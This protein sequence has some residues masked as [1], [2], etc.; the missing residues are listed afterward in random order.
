M[1]LLLTG[2]LAAAQDVGQLG[3]QKPFEIN[4]VLGLGLGTYH[5]DGIQPR[6]HDFSYLFNGAPI[7]SIY[8]I[9]LPFNIVVSDQ[10]RGFRQPFNQYGISP[11]YKWVT[12]HLGWQSVQF[13]QFT[14][15]GYD[16]L[17]GGVELNPGKWRLGFIYGRFNKAI[18]ETSSQP[19]SFQTPTYKRTGY[20]AKIGYG[21]E[22]THVDL[23]LLNAK[24]DPHSIHID[25]AAITPAENLVVGLDAKVSF[26]KHFVWDLDV[27]GSIYTRNK[28][29]DTIPNLELQ[30]FGFIKQMVTLNASSQLL[31]A[32]QT[33]LA[34]QGTNYTVGLQYRRVDPDYKSMGAYYFE[35]DV[36]NYTANGNLRLINNQVQLTGSFGR[37]HDNLLHDKSYTSYRNIGAL[38]VSYN[39]P[40]YGIDVHYSDFGITQDRGLNPIIDTFRV[41]RTNY[42]VNALLRY[43]LTDS[44]I[45]HSFIL[46]GTIQ[47]LADL[48]HFTAGQDETN[49]KTVNLSYQLGFIKSAF[50]VNA[51]YSYT[52]ADIPTMHT[53]LSGPSFTLSKQVDKGKIGLNATTSFQF[54]HNNG[55]DAGTVMNLALNGSYRIGAR[56][57]LNLMVS[58][59]KSNSTDATL[60]SFSEIMSMLNLTHSF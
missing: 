35:T 32:G 28:Y 27:A 43:S 44:V 56:D 45:T 20:S 19:L 59:L 31:T 30:N 37:Q 51:T 8:G 40:K 1:L 7:I 15:A 42:N 10:Q 9:A 46:V 57:G 47:S 54:Q 48:N 29:D 11:T 60:P 21:T 52:V 4:G 33:D 58:Y 26:L 2:G 34:Y 41:A 12:L 17:G 25:S 13:S 5:A 22:K 24:D 53:V 39:T 18:D 50:N 23:I 55:K 14:L 6:E 3:N 38:G 49:S 16:I 36:A